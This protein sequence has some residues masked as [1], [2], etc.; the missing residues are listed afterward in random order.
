MNKHFP[1]G[2]DENSKFTIYAEDALQYVNR[3]TSKKSAKKKRYDLIIHDV[4][5]EHGPIE[6]L[7]TL[8]V[9]NKFRALLEVSDNK[10]K[11]NGVLVANYWTL[12]PDSTREIAD[13]YEQVFSYVRVYGVPFNSMEQNCILVAHSPK[14]D[15]NYVCVDEFCEKKKGKKKSKKTRSGICLGVEKL[16]AHAATFQEIS[17]LTLD[18]E[19]VLNESWKTR[20]F[21]NDE[22]LC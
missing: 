4:F 16:A 15:N 19:L 3:L 14:L 6:A 8:A 17:N 7:N 22:S 20:P 10:N 18:F 21:P 12:S 2:I 11:E 1:F 9:F 13:K 5:D